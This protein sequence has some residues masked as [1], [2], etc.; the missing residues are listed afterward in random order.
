MINL[1]LRLNR[2]PKLKTCSPPCPIHYTNPPARGQES[3][4]GGIL[5]EHFIGNKSLCTL[6]S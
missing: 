5:M 2:S 6:Y 1:P 4:T 3:V